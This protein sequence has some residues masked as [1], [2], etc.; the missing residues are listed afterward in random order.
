MVLSNC[1]INLFHESIN[2]WQ[3]SD[4][5]KHNIQMLSLRKSG[6]RLYVDK[7]QKLQLISGWHK[8]ACFFSS[9]MRNQAK[10]DVKTAINALVTQLNT[11][12]GKTLK[13][14]KEVIQD[15]EEPN[16]TESTDEVRIEEE[17]EQINEVVE[18][19]DIEDDSFKQTPKLDTTK[20][21]VQAAVQGFFF[22]QLAAMGESVFDRKHLSKQDDLLTFI[23]PVY[24]Q[25]HAKFKD[26]PKERK[27]L[28]SNDA[29]YNYIEKTIKFALRF[30]VKPELASK[31]NNGTYFM[32]NL[33]G[34]RVG[35][36]KPSD[37]QGASF[38]APKFKNRFKA[39]LGWTNTGNE[40]NAECIATILC[41]KLN[42]QNVPMTK[43]ATFTSKAFA[44]KQDKE[45]SLQLYITL[46]AVSAKEQFKLGKY[47]K[48]P[49][50]SSLPLQVEFELMS[51]LD[52]ALGNLDRHFSNWFIT[53]APK[54]EETDVVETE[55]SQVKPEILCIDNGYAMLDTHSDFWFAGKHQYDWEVLPY[56]KNKFSD[57]AKQVI[58]D[59]SS[60]ADEIVKDFEKLLAPEQVQKPGEGNRAYQK[61]LKVLK[62]YQ[63]GMIKC[64]RDR[65]AVLNAYQ[66]KT[67]A[68]LAKV[69]TT[70]Q[71]TAALAA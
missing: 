16:R 59:L 11:E 54:K 70:K 7:N 36:F 61:R 62:A 15:L 28:T 41:K 9:K 13:E 1:Q 57:Q 37:E 38:T 2:S 50:D 14:Q 58:N 35:V 26:Y 71:V 43:M 40:T 48:P 55:T 31:G 68:E 19:N 33:A 5:D 52:Y 17:V 10:A 47:F 27:H 42:L 20:L 39:C 12:I 34:Q 32:T 22:N 8:V 44:Y 24:A 45:G 30:G 53:K 64:F 18:D 60:K 51:I 4:A 21:K 6:Q 23:D 67:P 49:T 25:M 69:K 29:Y 56:A 65:V 3:L 63:A 46:P 66:D